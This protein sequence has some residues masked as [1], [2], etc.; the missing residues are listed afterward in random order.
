MWDIHSIKKTHE[1]IVSL[2][3]SEIKKNE[4]KGNW[5]EFSLAFQTSF[6]KDVCKDREKQS[7]MLRNI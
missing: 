3:Y 2:I 1:I 6:P 4:G 5:C 7:T